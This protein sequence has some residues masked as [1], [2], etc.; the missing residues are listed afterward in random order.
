MNSLER[1]L[2]ALR[3]EEPDTVTI[4]EWIIED[5]VILKIM[6]G[7]SI[8]DFYDSFDIDGVTIYEDVD[9]KPVSP[10]IKRD[11][12][13]VLRDFRDM[14][15]KL[16]FPFPV[17]PLIN[18]EMDPN[19]FL[20]TYKMPD[21]YDPKRLATLRATVKKFK[22]KK[23]IIFAVHHGLIYPIFIRGFEN[24]LMDYYL[25]PDFAKKLAMMVNDY[26]VE[27]EKQAIEIGADIITDGE[28][29][30]G[31]DGLFMSMEHF[32]E[33]V[34]PGLRNVIKVAKDNNIPFIKHSDGNLWPILD[35][36]VEEGIDAI[37][38]I[39][40]AA[41]MDIGEVKKVYGDRVA[42]HG[43]IDCAHLLTFGKPKDVRNAVKDCIR[44]A[45]SGGGHILASS[46]SIHAGV[47]PE[48]F[49]A[50][51]EAAREFGKYPI[52]V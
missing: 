41:G 43:N 16:K 51:V 5:P 18:K 14:E 15:G 19:K 6:A 7:A 37:N 44:K 22:G 20:E 26:F 40:P 30:C 39:E 24:Y 17:E 47:P 3:L 31:K 4:V 48:N 52:R 34:L 11:H 1:V 21:P 23:A 35:L 8:L 27:L 2:A 46:N 49:I 29:Y 28:D 45:S 36:L 10:G 25:N 9:F 12:F 50:M 42:I 38:P 32:R 13:G 33:F